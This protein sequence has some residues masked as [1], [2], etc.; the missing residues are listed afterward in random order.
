VNFATAQIGAVIHQQLWML[1]G[2]IDFTIGKDTYRLRSGDC[3][4]VR[5][6]RP[7]VFHNPTARSAL[8]GRRGRGT[9]RQKMSLCITT[10]RGLRVLL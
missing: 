9:Y 10:W 5:L 6:D 1:E 7:T 8:R 2:T 3:L 4:A